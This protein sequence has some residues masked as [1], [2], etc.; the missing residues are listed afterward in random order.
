MSGWAWW[1][2]K[3]PLHSP[4]W[5][6][7]PPGRGVLWEYW[8]HTLHCQALSTHPTNGRYT[9]DIGVHTLVAAVHPLDDGPEEDVCVGPGHELRAVWTGNSRARGAS[10]QV[11]LYVLCCLSWFPLA[12]LISPTPRVLSIGLYAHSSSLPQNTDRTPAVG[13]VPLQPL[14]ACPA[15]PS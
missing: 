9:S 10:A 7:P 6:H 1:H 14:S 2:G 4:S 8:T 12:E 3:S 13:D 5:L 11:G 15:C